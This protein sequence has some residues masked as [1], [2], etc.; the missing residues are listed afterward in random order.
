LSFRALRKPWLAAAQVTL[1]VDL[2]WS[3]RKKPLPAASTG[4]EQ[5]AALGQVAEPPE[6]AQQAARPRALEDARSARR[7]TLARELYPLL[8]DMLWGARGWP[9]VRLVLAIVI[10]LVANMF[11]QVRLNE[12][13]GAFFDAVERRNST[14]FL[15]QVFLVIVAVLLI[16]VVAQTWLQE[17]LKMDLLQQFGSEF[18]LL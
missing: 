15:L 13:N 9:I 18:Q 14:A 11:G 5:E 4:V 7:V 10:V 8:R 16:L 12:W 6:L 17:R 2:R 3:A 1:M